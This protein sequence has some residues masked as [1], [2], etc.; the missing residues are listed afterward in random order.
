MAL[1]GCELSNNGQGESR[2]ECQ[3]GKQGLAG[4]AVV[5]LRI[6]KGSGRNASKEDGAPLC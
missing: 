1:Q 2:V 4:M 6:F 3:D 5:G